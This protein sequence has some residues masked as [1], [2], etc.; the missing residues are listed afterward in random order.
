[1]LKSDCTYFKG[2]RPCSYN[3]NEGIMCNNCK[4]YMPISFKILIIKL[5]AIGDVLRT[6]SIL[7]PLK[8]KYPSSYIQWCTRQNAS[9]LFK[10]NSLV[11]EVI[12]IEDDAPFRIKA[13]SYDIVINLDTSKISSAIA[14]CTT[15]KQKIGFVLNKMGYVEPATAA[16]NVWL[17]MSA[18]D[19]FKKEN[20]KSNQQLMYEIL[21]LSLPVEK[22]IIILSKKEKDKISEK[23][24]LK[25]INPKKSILGLNVGIGTK[26]PSKGWPLS[27]WKE[28]IEKLSTSYY[29][30]LL[31]GGP[32]EVGAI[33]QLKKEYNFLIDT[34]CDNSL[35][36]F[37]AIVDL[38]DL[39]ITAD[40]L[41]LHIATALDKKIIA[42]FGPTSLAEIEL[43]G[44]GI[45]LSSPD[46]CNCYYRKYCSEEISCMEKITSEMV[47]R[48]INSLLKS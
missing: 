41:A 1:M 45:K 48:A 38:C 26:W 21:D 18:F 7:Q 2:D 29:N 15:A 4:H 25:E 22:P 8:K 39:V 32:E 42:L 14:T 44:K 36:E 17:E 34:G 35:F 27:R 46:G 28:L 19:Q 12:T 13:E 43:Y 30:L 6:T 37:A 40:T 11:D 3:K 10:N 20:K 31:L 24:F 23:N 16:S 47:L 5:D 9:D 33:I